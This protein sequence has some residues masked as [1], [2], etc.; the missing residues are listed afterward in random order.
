MGPLKGVKVIEM[1][2]IGP[3]P[4]CAMLL[5][6]M[7]AEVLRID[8]ADAVGTRGERDP[9]FELL[10]R[11]RRSIALDLK[12]PSAID[13][14][15]RLIEAADVLIEGFRPGVMERLG[16]G[17]QA[18]HKVNPRLVY[19]RMTGWGQ[20][21]P[22]AQAAGHDIN[23]IAITG[24]LHAI[25]RAD[26]APV[27]PLNLVGDFGGGSLYLAL[28]IACALIE[29]RQSGLGQVVDAAIVD[30]TSSLITFLHGAMARK[31]WTSERGTN[32][33]DGG[34][35]W[36]DS[37]VTSDGSYVCI[38]PIEERFYAEF[39]KRVGLDAGDLPGQNDP[40]GWPILRERF[41]ALFKTRTR[42]DW[43]A[44]LEG[45]DACFAPVLSAAEAVEHPHNKAR[46]A[47]V[48]V[49]GVTQPAPAP[50]FSRTHADV[51][52]PAARAGQHTRRALADWGLTSAEVESLIATR[53][54]VQAEAAKESAR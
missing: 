11:G 10:N 54:A 8:R 1:A 37:Y 6:D 24:A 7:G 18:C 51:P 27:P 16:L 30:G 44:L 38:G 52:T 25:G 4:F 2:G 20:D 13:T 28:G 9:S 21:G 34:R 41:A 12:Q 22:L 33:L 43:C 42:A 15:L 36:Y 39:L 23:Y 45:T 14:V 47:F 31:A 46:G 50:R 32:L 53:A 40:T 19:G 35:P 5:A 29:A 3:G 49:A 26:G 48:D 17:P